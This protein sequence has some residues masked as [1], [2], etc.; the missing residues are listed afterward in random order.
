LRGKVERFAEMSSKVTRSIP[1]IE[2]LHHDFQSES[3][4]L[5]A[6]PMESEDE[7]DKAENE[8]RAT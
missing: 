4:E 2:T 7:P 5:L 6:E 1:E 8:S 3:L